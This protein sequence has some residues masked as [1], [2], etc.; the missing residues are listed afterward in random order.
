[1]A[2]LSVQVN[3]T[4]N[5]G[6]E[7]VSNVVTDSLWFG[8]YGGSD[9]WGFARLTGITIPQGATINSATLH[10]YGSTV[11]GGS[12]YT[13]NATIKAEAAD[14]PV[15]P[16][17]THKPSTLTL[18]TAGLNISESSTTWTSVDHAYNI[19]SVIQELVNRAGWASGNAINIILKNN[20]TTGNKDLEIWDYG[21]WAEEA[22]YVD[23]DYT[24]GGSGVSGV[25]SAT[26]DGIGLSAAGLAA[27][28][29]TAAVTLDGVGLNAAGGVT[30]LGQASLS[31]DGM[32]LAAGG[33]VAIAGAVA[34]TLEGI[35]IT[36][37]GLVG[38]APVL[39]VLS[40]TL[41]GIGLSAVGKAAV[42]GSAAVTLEGIELNAAGGVA[43]LGQASL[44]LDGMGLAAGGGVAIAGAA[45]VTLEGIGISVAGVV[46]SVPLFGDLAESLDELVISA[47]GQVEIAGA[48]TVTL[49]GIGLIAWQGVPG[50]TI[51]GM[52]VVISATMEAGDARPNWAMNAPGPGDDWVIE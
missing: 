13:V 33:G 6:N 36:A 32:G 37:T 40:A 25:L 39:G 18:T 46:G 12:P 19:T 38:T 10:A 47:S 35:G 24:E 29:G 5:D 1:M 4:A 43:I 31:L 11:E 2:T 21:N 23:F 28:A 7:Y 30:I 50:W 49:E 44:S 22:L 9:V 20:G 48:A 14:N 26:L 45:A 34:V 3:A 42:A 27:I 41:E 52:A 17:N 15:V 8:T 16:S 51:L